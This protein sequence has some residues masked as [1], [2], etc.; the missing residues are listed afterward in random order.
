MPSTNYAYVNGRFVPEEQATVSIFDRGFLYGDGVFET[1]RV[2]ERK[3]FRPLSHMKRL[4]A[5]LRYLGIMPPL[6]PEELRAV[7]EVLIDRNHVESGVARV[8]VTSG[9]G[10]LGPSTRADIGSTLVVAAQPRKFGDIELRVIIAKSRLDT[11]LSPYKTANRLPYIL[12]RHEAEKVRADE[13]ILL[14]HNGHVVEFS[15]SNLFVVRGGELFTPP[16]SDGPLPGITRSDILMLAEELHLKVREESLN[17]AALS[18][19]RN[20]LRQTV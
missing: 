6:T 10:N 20:C 11:G 14:S 18:K 1:M 17:E 7:S 3:V 8:Y 9:A 13:A 16:L 2:Y 5:G 19:P 15:A 4:A 12:A